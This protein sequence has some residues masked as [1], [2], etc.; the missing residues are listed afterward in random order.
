M[1]AAPASRYTLRVGRRLQCWRGGS[2]ASH[3]YVPLKSIQYKIYV[4][5][6]NIGSHASYIGKRDRGTLPMNLR[7][8]LLIREREGGRNQ[9]LVYNHLPVVE[10]KLTA[11]SGISRF[12]FSCSFSNKSS[13]WQLIELVLL[14]VLE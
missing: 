6:V 11:Y 12:I 8:T 5:P 14:D 3:R 7:K 10:I 4:S 1:E 2:G 13:V 9:D